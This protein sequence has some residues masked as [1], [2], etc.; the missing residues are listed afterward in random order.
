MKVDRP[1]DLASIRGRLHS[2][3]RAELWLIGGS[4]DLNWP[5]PIA[6]IVGQDNRI[7]HLTSMHVV[8][9]LGKCV[10]D[11][12][13][14]T[15]HHIRV[16]PLLVPHDLLDGSLL[17]DSLPIGKLSSE[18]TSHCLGGQQS[19]QG[20]APSR[21]AVGRTSHRASSLWQY[22]YRSDHR[23]PSRLCRD[24][25]SFHPLLPSHPRKPYDGP[26]RRL[27]EAPPETTRRRLFPL[28]QK[29]IF[30]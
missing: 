8:V 6:P 18:P 10:I 28:H 17:Q 12:R 26:E 22:L 16:R 21:P 27:E 19:H 13:T 30:I 11:S 9:E 25:P 29:S 3:R 14:P 20:V 4:H 2:D 7:E 15:H 1:G 5:F 24:Y 23:Q